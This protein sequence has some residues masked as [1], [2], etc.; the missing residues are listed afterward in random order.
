MDRAPGSK[1]DFVRGK[2]GG[3]PFWPGG[4]ENVLSNGTGIKLDEMSH[5]GLKTVPPGFKRGLR[6]TGEEIDES[7]LLA[8]DSISVNEP[9]DQKV[10]Q[11]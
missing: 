4:M 8:F 10:C 11:K 7:E 1:K 6:L 9:E 2:S 3:V 5:K